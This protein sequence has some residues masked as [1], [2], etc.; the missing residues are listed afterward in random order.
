MQEISIGKMRAMQRCTS[1]RGT[2]TCLALDHRQNLR[3]SLNSRNVDQVSDEQLTN[4]KLGVASTLAGRAT[5]VLLDP[6]YSA[7]QAVSKMMVPRNT[8][9][10]VAVESTGYGGEPT[11]RQSQVLPGWSVRKAKRMGADMIKL[12][13]YYHPDSPTAAEIE[14]LCQ[15]N[16][17][18]MHRRG[19]G[20]DAGTVILFAGPIQNQTGFY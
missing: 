1:E 13:V 6:Q 3:R 20:F 17:S 10:V 9:L 7:A 12:L 5:A 8:G 4:F 11:A 18:T 19:S 15:E 16:C 14:G 2:F